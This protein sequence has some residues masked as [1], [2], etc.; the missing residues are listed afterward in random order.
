MG[1]FVLFEKEKVY[2]FDYFSENYNN[3][4]KFSEKTRFSAFSRK[5]IIASEKSCRKI[6]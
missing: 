4:V 3:C 1:L 2:F 6:L 5:L